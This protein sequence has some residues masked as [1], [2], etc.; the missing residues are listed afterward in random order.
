MEQLEALIV[1]PVKNRKTP[2]EEWCILPNR[3]SS[4]ALVNTL[5]HLENIRVLRIR[6]LDVSRIPPSRLKS[7]G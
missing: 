2:L 5:K 6:K 4:P 3:V 7:L 1:A